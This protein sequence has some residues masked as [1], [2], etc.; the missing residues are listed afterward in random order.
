MTGSA[1]RDN[2]GE[3]YRDLPAL[4]AIAYR[5][6]S[7]ATEAEDV[8]QDAYLRFQGRRPREPWSIA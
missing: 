3:V 1:T 8:V 5:M 6:L 7:S 4:F 2:V